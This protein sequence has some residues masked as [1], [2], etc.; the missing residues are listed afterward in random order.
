M[1]KVIIFTFLL[2]ICLARISFA[3]DKAGAQ[4]LKVK[5]TAQDA[6]K[7]EK[8]DLDLRRAETLFAD[9]SWEQLEKST[10]ESQADYRKR[11]DKLPL[12]FKGMVFLDIDLRLVQFRYD[13]EKQQLSFVLQ[14]DFV[15][16]RGQ[17]D[18][19]SR[20]TLASVTKTISENEAK[21]VIGENITIHNRN[22]ENFQFNFKNMKDIPKRLRIMVNSF[23]GIGFTIPMA[24]ET[25][26]QLLAHNELALVFGV[27]AEPLAGAHRYYASFEARADTPSNILQIN[28][29]IPAR[30]L[31][32]KL[33]N[34][35]SH[36]VLASWSASSK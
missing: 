36:E 13:A 11:I 34:R 4:A 23:E 27:A 9:I 6:K 5:P 35:V 18:S 24:G 14:R 31:D 32:V 12:P 21:T 30:L 16:L 26:K 20:F 3:Q 7:P 1:K 15:L 2:F 8:M 28:Y 17:S 22:V 29:E 33:Y 10:Y 25:A 19:S